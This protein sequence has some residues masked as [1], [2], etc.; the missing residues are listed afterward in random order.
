MLPHN[1]KIQRRCPCAATGVILGQPSASIISCVTLVLQLLSARVVVDRIPHNGT[2]SPFGPG[3]C[4]A[5]GPCSTLDGHAYSIDWSISGEIGRL[6]AIMHTCGPT[7]QFSACSSNP[8]IISRHS[9]ATAAHTQPVTADTFS[10]VSAVATALIDGRA[11]ISA[12]G[13]PLAGWDL[14][15][16]YC[17]W[18]G[19]TCSPEGKHAIQSL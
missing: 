12:R 9:Q 10:H 14:A 17:S 8:S 18:T 19:V 1:S 2:I 7:V 5:G 3:K 13:T 16:S 6:G 4:I 15:T 11:V